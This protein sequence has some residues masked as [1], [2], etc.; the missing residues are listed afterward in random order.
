M[1]RRIINENWEFIREDVGVGGF[2][3]SGAASITLPHT[4]NALDGQD[5]GNDFY[6]GRCW[7]R[8]VLKTEVEAAEGERSWIEFEAANS[9]AEVFIN[10]KSM[11]THEGGYSA[12]RF[13]ISDALKEGENEIL[14]SVDNSHRPDIYPL[15]AD[16]TFFGGIYRDAAIITAG[17]V[18]FNLDD[19]G[20]PGIF[21]KT[22]NADAI[23]AELEIRSLMVIPEGSAS[24]LILRHTLKTAGGETA[25]STELSDLRPGKEREKTAVMKVDSPRL[26]NGTED[27][28]LYQLI[29]EL[30][31]DGKVADS[32]E[33]PVGIRSL[34]IDPDKGFILNGKPLRLNGMSRHQDRKDIGWAL[35][36]KNQNEDMNIL[37]E[38]GSN[39]VRL[40]H[41]QHNQYFYNL[42]DEKGIVAWAEIPFISSMSETDESGANAKSQIVELVKQNF[43]HPS[44][45]FWGVQN[46]ITIG[47]PDEAIAS[48]V[49]MLNDTVKSLDSSRIT[50]QAQVGHHPDDDEMNKTTDA[51]GYN[52]YYGWYYDECED[53]DPWLSDFASKQSDIPLAITEYGCEGLLQWHSEAPKKNDYSE[54]YQALYHEKVLNIFNRHPRL[55]ATYNWNLFD[56][57]SDFR[58]EG[59]VKGMNNKGLVTHDR[60]TRKDSFFWYKVNWSAEPVLHINSRRF[61][62]RAGETVDVKV[63]S[64]REPVK[65]T[66]N[67]AS[68]GKAKDLYASANPGKAWIF[69][70]VPL[71]MGENLIIA[72]AGDETEGLKDEALFI[73]VDAADES[74]ICPKSEGLMDSISNWFDKDGDEDSEPMVF[75]KGFFSVKDKISKILKVPGGKAALEALMPEMFDHPMFGIMKAF[76]F[77]K[78]AGMKPEFFPE[79]FMKKL[80]RELNKVSKG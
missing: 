58:D 71:A 42:C 16:F 32:R 21:V 49:S 59:G 63:Y 6:R 51:L 37:L 67:G 12:F 66:V 36:R 54:E 31:L 20:S 76:S 39:A 35:S 13:D 7:Y 30:I 48:V 57:A 72:E 38:I 10:G 45:A 4:W 80:N 55:W 44:I 24:G 78:L 9:V 14:V 29:S 18:R 43:N 17:D 64:N 19:K 53:F 46:E 75:P 1:N 28:Y 69:R 65:L 25:A 27:P 56:F 34:A 23:S 22:L 77:E 47:G 26:W 62:N 60:Q 73:R 8:R 41:Y 68:A 5:G 74:Y 79:A 70:N 2:L 61:V 3:T 52:K 40:A 33:T 11:G 15:M 50:V